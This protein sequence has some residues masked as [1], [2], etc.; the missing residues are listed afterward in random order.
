M[1]PVFFESAFFIA[2]LVMAGALFVKSLGF[3]PFGKRFKQIANRK[4]IDHEADLT[5]PIHGLQRD[6]ELVRLP[7]GEPLCPLCYKEAVHGDI[8]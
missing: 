3:T 1:N 4:R 2:M 8:D 7:S 5:C 6:D